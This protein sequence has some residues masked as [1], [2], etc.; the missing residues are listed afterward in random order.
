MKKSSV[1]FLCLF[2]LIRLSAFSQNTDVVASITGSDK[3]NHYKPIVSFTI[4]GHFEKSVTKTALRNATS[5]SDFI[6]DYPSNWIENY[7]SVE[8]KATENGKSTTVRGANAALTAEQK[9]L[10]STI[11]INSKLEVNVN[12]HRKNTVNNNT[13]L[14][15]S[16]LVMSVVPETEAQF[17]GG[18]IK[19]NDY[20]KKNVVDKIDEDIIPLLGN[21]KFQFTIDETGKT[22]N[23]KMIS[24]TGDAK[25]DRLIIHA[26]NQMPA[27]T[28][29]MNETN[30]KVSQQFEFSLGQGGC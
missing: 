1:T 18:E 23:P 16:R 26:L 4:R 7:V 29:A 3:T 13:D 11:G 12:Y 21:G 30:N 9:K 15:T 17:A 27:W 19:L 2:L 6:K 14:H 25:T 22:V 28:P 10:L 8:L 24:S 5:L 20:I